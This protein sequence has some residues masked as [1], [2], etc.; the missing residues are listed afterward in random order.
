MGCMFDHGGVQLCLTLIG[1][2]EECKRFFT[3]SLPGGP[4]PCLV[5]RHNFLQFELHAGELVLEMPRLCLLG[6]S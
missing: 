5:E 3:F 1:Q 4:Q 2:V 6:V